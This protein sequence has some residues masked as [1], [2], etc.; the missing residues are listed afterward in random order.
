VTDGDLFNLAQLASSVERARLERGLTWAGLSREVGVAA[1]TIQRLAIASDAEADGVLA[2]IGWLGVPPE[3]FI[4]AS[5]VLGELLP[6]AR[7][8]FIRADMS[9]AADLP[10]TPA[11]SRPNARTSIQR[12]VATAQGAGRTVASLTRWSAV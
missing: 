5:S 7:G 9:L 2:L 4:V 11:R 10:S 8:G 6:P 3:D 1:S 12:L